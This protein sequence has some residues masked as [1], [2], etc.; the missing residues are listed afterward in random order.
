M[1]KPTAGIPTKD[2]LTTC[3]VTPVP[4]NTRTTNF[5]TRLNRAKHVFWYFAQRRYPGYEVDTNN[6]E[7]IVQC[8]AYFLGGNSRMFPAL[9]PKK[10]LMLV[11][12]VGT[13]KSLLMEILQDITRGIKG[14]GFRI[15]KAADIADEYALGSRG[16]AYG[17]QL[18]NGRYKIFRMCIDDLGFE[19][20]KVLNYGNESIPLAHILIKRSRLF[21]QYS[22]ITHLTTNLSA[23]EIERLY[24]DRIRDRLRKMCNVITL[25][26]KSR[27]K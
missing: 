13:G 6:K 11:G 25:E 18:R 26:G 5:D 7:A 23:D 17:E 2:R 27:R 22:E 1:E 8:L 14:Y 3:T 21:D 15:F 19:P 4:E 24:G 10:G 20:V 9:D 12:D 16:E